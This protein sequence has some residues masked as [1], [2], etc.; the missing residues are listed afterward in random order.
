[1]LTIVRHCAW[2][3]PLLLGWIPQ[4][5]L[6]LRSIPKHQKSPI[7]W[8]R[9]HEGRTSRCCPSPEVSKTEDRQHRPSLDDPKPYA[10]PISQSRSRALGAGGA[11]QSSPYTLNRDHHLPA[12][13]RQLIHYPTCLTRQQGS[14]ATTRGQIH[15][16]IR[17]GYGLGI[18]GMAGISLLVRKA[19][20]GRV[21]KSA[22]ETSTGSR[23]VHHLA[24][25]SYTNPR[26]TRT[27]CQRR[28]LE[29]RVAPDRSKRQHDGGVGGR[30]HRDSAYGKLKFLQKAT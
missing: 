29:V 11:K 23:F 8:D 21:G 9:H 14:K 12:P 16:K 3:T 10:P 17:I 7:R 6:E 30:G 26:T 13:S 15:M 25:R 4:T 27:L 2:P 20:L 28:F 18:S 19:T 24:G 5:G 22:Q 1:M